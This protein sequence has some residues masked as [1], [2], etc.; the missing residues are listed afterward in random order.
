MA[1]IAGFIL[2]CGNLWMGGKMTA[3][4][5]GLIAAF[6][7]VFSIGGVVLTPVIAILMESI[8]AEM[9]FRLFGRRLIACLAT[10]IALSLYTILHRIVALLVIYRAEIS[11]FMQAFRLFETEH[12]KGDI[13]FLIIII[14]Y[15]MLHIIIG[16]MVGGASYYSIRQAQER[17][18]NGQLPKS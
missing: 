1:S 7:K 11:D 8:I 10:G 3:I 2:C 18:T 12:S 9:M 15:I 6:L 14:G 17:F 13:R 16:S 5:M 4:Y